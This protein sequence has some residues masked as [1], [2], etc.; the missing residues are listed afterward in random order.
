MKWLAVLSLA[1]LAFSGCLEGQIGEDDGAADESPGFDSS[2]I[3]AGEPASGTPAQHG[4]PDIDEGPEEVVAPDTQS[5]WWRVRQTITIDNDFGGAALGD[6][7][8]DIPVGQIDVLPSPDGDY[9]YVL[10]L[11]SYGGTQQ[12][13]QAAFDRMEW[14]HTDRLEAGTLHLATAVSNDVSMG[15]S[16][17]GIPPLATCTG[18]GWSA[19]LIAKVPAAP[20]YDLSLESSTADLS[21]HDL[22][23]PS[24]MIDSST[25]DFVGDNLAFTSITRESST[26]DSDWGSVQAATFNH[27]SST[28]DVTIDSLVAVSASFSVST[29]DVEIDSIHANNVNLDG[30][31]SDLELRG[32]AVVSLMAETSTGDQYY[33]LKTEQATL[34]ASSGDITGEFSPTGSGDVQVRTSTG[35]VILEFMAGA[36]HGYDVDARSDTGD[37]DVSVT[38]GE[39][40]SQ[41]ENHVHKRTSG[42]AGRDIRTTVDITTQTG[43]ITVQA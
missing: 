12:E 38:D 41:D 5:P 43:D 42:F 23:G 6:V 3:P 10:Q 17:S 35:T 2:E 13:A 26:G 22:G 15:A 39:A 28:G 29:A 20:A 27:D 4:E 18:Q 24:L 32:G 9:H 33:K 21:V 8:V 37:I 19:E 14:E 40:V 34:I 7:F 36:T 11:E 30:T 16:C 31:T 1:M 25:G